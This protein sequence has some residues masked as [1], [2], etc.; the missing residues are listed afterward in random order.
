MS[1]RRAAGYSAGTGG[2]PSDG[3]R[4]PLEDRDDEG[5]L[6]G[7]Y[8]TER[9]IGQGAY[10]GLEFLHVNAKSII[11]TVPAASRMPFRY[12]INPYRGCSHACTYCFARPTHEYLGLGIGE[13]F[14]RRIVVKVNAVER[15]RAELFS[16]R[17]Q[18]DLIAM[19]TNTDPYQHA[20]GKYHLTKGIIGVLAERRNPF[21]ILTKS[22]LVL[23]DLALLAEAARFTQVRV[24]LSV[25]TIDPD[26]WRLTEP[27]TPPPLK[28]LDAVRRLNE[29]G[30]PCGV[31]I[32]PVLPGI[33]DSDEQV[34]AVAEA[35]RHAGAISAHV[36]A[37]HLRPGVREHYLSWLSAARPGL[38]GLYAERFRRGAY[39]SRREQERLAGLVAPSTRTGGAAA[40]IM[41]TASTAAGEG[42]L[43]QTESVARME[44]SAQQRR[45]GAPAQLALFG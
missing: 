11:N 6:F 38:V 44:G 10:E 17:W 20:E 41:V 18:G 7:G 13:D 9:H 26:V 43:D 16:S 36:L 15:A 29:A 21:S 23:R 3:L 45:A 34:A 39:Q 2:C 5:A 32:A 27:G 14:E 12:T 35:C 4:W 22:T 8:W 30:V 37:L 24:N 19:G 33:S 25:G 40:A 1:P 42:K 31:L 28:R